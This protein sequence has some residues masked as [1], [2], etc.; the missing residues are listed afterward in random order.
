MLEKIKELLGEE[1]SEQVTEK[2]GNVEI[3]ITNDGSLVPAEKHDTMKAELKAT[4]EQLDNV[5]VSLKEL[6]GSN[7]SIEE[8]Q[9]SGHRKWSIHNIRFSDR[10]KR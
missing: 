7:T 2:L 4:K 8:L 9:K 6:E 3:G 5:Q 10:N 1:L